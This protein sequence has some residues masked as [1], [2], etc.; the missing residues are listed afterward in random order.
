MGNAGE[1]RRSGC[2]A[3]GDPSLACARNWLCSSRA[4]RDGPLPPFAPPGSSAGGT[5]KTPACRCPTTPRVSRE[6]CPVVGRVYSTGKDLR[7][8]KEREHWEEALRGPLRCP[9][10]PLPSFGPS[11]S[12]LPSPTPSPLPRSRQEEDEARAGRQE[13][14]RPAG[15]PARQGPGQGEP[16]Q[17]GGGGGHRRQ[18]P[19]RAR[20]QPPAGARPRASRVPPRAC[21]RHPHL[22]HHD[23]RVD[24]CHL[25]HRWRRP[26]CARRPGFLFCR[27]HC[28]RLIPCRACLHRRGG[29][30]PCLSG[31]SAWVG[32]SSSSRRGGACMHSNA[33]EQLATVSSGSGHRFDFTM[34]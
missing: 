12:P 27:P 5:T 20:G 16:A 31:C 2:G 4:L 14:G 10:S 17:G 24:A 8:E 22:L 9:S 19:H 26:R 15:G 23:H 7:K 34:F 1:G 21:C 25:H 29:G 32:C 33:L 3:A 28:A 11:S 13:E 30:Q 6:T 18:P